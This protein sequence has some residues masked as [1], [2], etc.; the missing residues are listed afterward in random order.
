M[1]PEVNIISGDASVNRAGELEWGGGGG[2]GGGW[3]GGALNPS[4]GGFRGLS[5]LR[6]FV[7]SKKHLDWLKIDLNVVKVIAV[8]DN[9]H[10]KH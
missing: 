4:A 1:I 3:G 10:T 9:K 8:P 5:S 2:G 6:K 7:G